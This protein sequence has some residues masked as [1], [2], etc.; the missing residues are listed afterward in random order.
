MGEAGVLFHFTL[1]I[2]LIEVGW[3]G[4]GDSHCSPGDFA[5]FLTVDLSGGLG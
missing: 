1:F 4:G 5:N 2:G 3:P